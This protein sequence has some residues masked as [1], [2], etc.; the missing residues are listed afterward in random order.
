MATAQQYAEWLVKNQDKK[1]TPDFETVAQAYKMARTNKV[2]TEAV[3]RR[4]FDPTADMSTFEK[5]AAG[6]GK[7]VYDAGRGIGQMVGLVSRD[8]VAKAREL[9]AP[10][11]STT[12]GVVGNVAG[13]VAMTLLP[14][15]V[16]RTAGVMAKAPALVAAGNALLAPKTIPAALAV[17]SGFGLLQ[18]STST[19]ETF[20]NMGIGGLAGAAVPT[21]VRGYQAARAAA[22]PFYEAGRNRIVGRAIQQAAGGDAG[23]ISNIRAAAQPFV[24]PPQEGQA[25]RTIMGEIVPGSIPTVAQVAK[26]PSLAAMERTAS[27][28]DPVV[29]NGFGQRMAAQN[30]ARVAMLDDMAGSG[31]AR[32]FF[33]AAREATGDSL[34]SEAFRQG[35]DP[36]K[37][38]QYAPEVQRLLKNP[39]VKDAI[40]VAQRL[41][42][43]DEI[44]L[45]DPAGS[46]Q[47]LHYIKKALDDMLD[48]G[49]QTGIGKIEAAKIASTKDALLSLM[50][51]L[52]PAYGTARAEFQAASRPLNQMDTVAALAEKSTNK[53]TGRVEPGA[54]ARN[55]TDATVQKATGFKGAT[56]DNT[57]DPAQRNA[58]SALFDDLQNA[59]FAQNA[60]RNGSDTVQKLAYSNMLAESGVPNWLRNFAPAQFTGNL[61]ARAGDA[62]Y[63]RANRELA[64]RLAESLLNPQTAAEM[65]QMSLGN[66][67]RL[68][69]IARGGAGAGLTVPAM[70]SGSKE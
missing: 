65:L 9:D 47:G 62:A 17:G 26:S 66:Q 11:M 36:K 40:P 56:L 33:G 1:G 16:L 13:N 31:G 4:K 8:D 50:D 39:A 37:A 48:K 22:E 29:A 41:A 70:L 20:L 69:A 67:N 18:P 15:G 25:A 3:D 49:K 27:Q 6:A 57:F 32:E 55:L 23:A 35:I 54:F 28:V 61:A 19:S 68:L 42:Q 2:M 5:V 38:A 34:Y 59:A 14:G 63:G 51:S 53:L 46:L 60:G 58:L 21:A 64:N 12:G 44:D 45:A 30:T 10:L 43:F 52:S 7:A 24:G